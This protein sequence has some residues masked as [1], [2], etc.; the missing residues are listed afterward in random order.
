M[1]DLGDA[2]FKGAIADLAEARLMD[3]DGTRRLIGRLERVLSEEMKNVGEEK[4][5]VLLLVMTPELD[6]FGDVVSGRRV[7]ATSSIAA[8]TWAR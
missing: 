8:S 4:F 1:S 3:R 7:R 6:Q 2:A 5:L